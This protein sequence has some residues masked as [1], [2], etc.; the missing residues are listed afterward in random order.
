MED[1]KTFRTYLSLILLFLPAILFGLLIFIYKDDAKLNIIGQFPYLP[2]QFLIIT[3]FGIIAT[4]GGVLDWS[5]H[6]NPLRMKIPKKERDAEAA[7]LGL[8][9]IP[10]FILMWLAM[11]NSKPSNYLIP[12]LIVLIYTVVA[13]SYD[14]FVFHI[15]RCGKLET[16]YHRL[17]VFGNAIAWLSWFHYIY[18]K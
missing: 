17:L 11:M 6:R 15:K 8:G 16:F 5:F 2:W 14:E 9:G 10:M 3:I 13:I 4:I 12:I 7:A 1:I 18:C